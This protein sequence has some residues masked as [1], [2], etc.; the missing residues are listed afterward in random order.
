ML[1]MSRW[2]VVVLSMQ[3]CQ[4][5]TRTLLAALCI[6][7]LGPC[8]ICRMGLN[9]YLHAPAQPAKKGRFSRNDVTLFAVAVNCDNK[10]VTECDVRLLSTRPNDY[11]I[12]SGRLN[13]HD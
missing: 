5:T 8:G 6:M 7:R 11:S 10:Q 2:M 12:T 4:T 1:L 3:N 9:K 13:Q